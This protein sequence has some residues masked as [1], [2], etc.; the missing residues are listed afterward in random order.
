MEKQ[1][2]I[3]PHTVSVPRL[4]PAS[5]SDISTHS[6]YLVN[7]EDFMKIVILLRLAIPYTGLIMTARESPS[8][9]RKFYPIM[10]QRDASTNIKI[11]G[12]EETFQQKESKQQ[13]LLGDDRSL[14]EVICELANEGHITSFCT[15]GYRCREGEFC[16]LNAILTFREWLDDFASEETKAAGEI[17]I[18]KEIDEV[19]QRF[20]STEYKELIEKYNSIQ[21]GSRDLYF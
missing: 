10:T 12:Y 21:Q 15:A 4:Q 7:D 5:N 13:F 1:F 16:K 8:T 18:Q 20:A 9:L 14:D 3:G 2:G 17:I 6:K 19:Q 11:G